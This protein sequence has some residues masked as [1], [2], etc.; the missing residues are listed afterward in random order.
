MLVPV[1]FSFIVEYEMSRACMMTIQVPFGIRSSAMKG[2]GIAV[3]EGDGEAFEAAAEGMGRVT[4]A[5]TTSNAAAKARSPSGRQGVLM[6][7]KLLWDGGRR[8]LSGGTT[9]RSSRPGGQ[10]R[11][12]PK[13]GPIP[14][15][16]YCGKPCA[17][18]NHRDI[19]GIA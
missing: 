11:G 7:G 1:A 17:V 5:A 2:V 19:P 18:Q 15:A 9:N 14:R 16:R 3:G 6:K 10:A 8:T 4:P 13:R 12:G